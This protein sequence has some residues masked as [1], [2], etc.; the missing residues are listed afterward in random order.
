MTQAYQID[1]LGMSMRATPQ[2]AQMT[3]AGNPR[4][5]YSQKMDFRI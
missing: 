1:R 3:Y 5:G 4:S 2:F